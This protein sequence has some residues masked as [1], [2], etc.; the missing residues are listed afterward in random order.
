[1]NDEQ[2]DA[3]VSAL[4]R[5]QMLKLI[6]KGFYKELLNYGI[7]K[8]NIITVSSHLLDYLLKDLKNTTL[9]KS[10][11]YY[12]SLFTIKNIKNEWN[13]NERLVLK[14]V[15]ISPLKSDIYPQ[16]AVWLS[17]PAI[18][19]NFISLYPESEAGLGAYF[20][21]G[22]RRYF[23][24]YYKNEP[25]GAI[26]A[27]NIDNE[28]KKLEM[29]KF[30]G[31]TG[32]QGKGIGKSATFLFLYYSF[33]IQNIDK[34]YIH[35]GDTNIRN[36]ILNSKFGFELEGLFF[37]DVVVQSK[38]RDVVRMGLLKARWMEIFSNGI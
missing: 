25:V 35:S 3:V 5:D 7:T 6:T 19:Y 36:I 14:D 22:A 23:V 16:I 29:R 4:Q 38:K 37:D 26:G 11:E 20:S 30:I 21:H 28:S 27:D 1:M 33:L 12:N 24:I 18:K 9:N 32:L 8:E 10:D 17:N 31:N 15:S 13:K 34:V 2:N